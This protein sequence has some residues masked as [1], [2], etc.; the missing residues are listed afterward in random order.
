MYAGPH[1]ENRPLEQHGTQGLASTGLYYNWE[2][3]VDDERRIRQMQIHTPQPKHSHEQGMQVQF[4]AQYPHA[5]TFEHLQE[6]DTPS[7]SR[8]APPPPVNNLAP[9][10]SVN[11]ASSDQVMNLSPGFVSS[12]MEREDSS[13]QQISRPSSAQAQMR[14]TSM[15]A[16]A[17]RPLHQP[18]NQIGQSR[19]VVSNRGDRFLHVR[20]QLQSRR[21]ENPKVSAPESDNQ[22]FSEDERAQPAQQNNGQ[23]VLPENPQLSAQPAKKRSHEEMSN[24]LDYSEA[25]LKQKRLSDLQAEPFP[26]DPRTAPQAPIR[27][28][29]G[30]EMALS[31][32]LDNLSKMSGDA[33]R[34]TFKSLTDEQWA[35]TGQWFVEKFQTELKKLMEVRLE[36][37][38]IALNYEDQI[39]RRQ[40]VVEQH[41]AQLDKELRELQTGGKQLVDGRKVPTGSRS[42]TPMKGGR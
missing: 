26:Q 13:E 15:H 24:G 39:R 5:Q 37:R 1:E 35:N 42:G 3:E 21:E 33:Q 34:E 12:D 6:P 31:Q 40:R 22:D 8:S 18:Q 30:N 38:K 4:R 16:K 11:F 9:Q 7:R 41:D 36:R 2:A 23:E 14:S 25:D 28:N 19:D 20:E 17:Q 29:V 10:K 32:I 27:D